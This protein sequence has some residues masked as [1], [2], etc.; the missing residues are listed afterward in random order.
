MLENCLMERWNHKTSSD[1]EKDD[2]LYCVVKLAYAFDT[3]YYSNL[4]NNIFVIT[5]CIVKI[6]SID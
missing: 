2:A 5:Q 4:S 3:A 6:K 1:I